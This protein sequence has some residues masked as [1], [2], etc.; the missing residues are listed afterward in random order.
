MAFILSQEVSQHVRS[1]AC[2]FQQAHLN[3]P[4]LWNCSQ[5]L[6]TT[7]SQ[8]ECFFHEVLHEKDPKVNKEDLKNYKYHCPICPKSFKKPSLRRHL[9]QHT[10]ERPY[11]CT[12]CGANFTRQSS[13]ANHSRREH[14]T[15]VTPKMQKL[16]I[17]KEEPMNE[18]F[19]CLRCKKGFNSK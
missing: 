10:F 13:L 14:S 3:T 17:V 6:Y 11:V 8:A 4:I 2:Q 16:A 12:I 5:C 9:R 15:E 18:E 7:D 1:K 19:N